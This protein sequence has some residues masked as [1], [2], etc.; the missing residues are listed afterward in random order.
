MAAYRSKLAARDAA[1][2]G[3]SFEWY[4]LQNYATSNEW[5]D[6]TQQKIVCKRETSVLAFCLDYRGCATLDTT[7]FATGQ[8]LK[9]LLGVLNSKLGRYMLQDAPHLP[10][11]D[12]Q[13]SVLT[14]EALKIP[15]PNIKVESE[16]ISLVNKRTSDVHKLENEEL[17]GKIDRLI[18]EM[19]DLNE[20]ERRFID[21][22]IL[23]T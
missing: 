12:M 18:Y 9:Y 17:D 16:V 20:E 13:I 10:N 23:H 5:D 3:V 22:N 19:Y 6:F 21:S 15:I 7:C 11:G 14:L 4:A 1:E 8:H 2:V